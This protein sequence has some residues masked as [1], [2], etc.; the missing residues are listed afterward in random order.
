MKRCGKG[1]V[2]IGIIISKVASGNKKSLEI[3]SR[4][5]VGMIVPFFSGTYFTTLTCF[6]LTPFSVS[7]RTM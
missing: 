7:T 1:K 5:S 2:F 3:F 6:T 4:L